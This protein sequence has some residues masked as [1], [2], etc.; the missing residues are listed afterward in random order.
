MPDAAYASLND[1]AYDALHLTFQQEARTS[2]TYCSMLL[3][4]LLFY[5]DYLVK[6]ECGL[7]ATLRQGQ[8]ARQHQVR[9]E[10]P[11]A[12]GRTRTFRY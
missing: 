7:K 4:K 1:R 3:K 12:F 10:D 9:L 8:S 6:L 5:E 11:R 2:D